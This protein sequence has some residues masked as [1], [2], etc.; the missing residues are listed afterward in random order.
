MSKMPLFDTVMQ[1][2]PA[3]VLDIGSV[4]TKYE[5]T[6]LV[7]TELNHKIDFRLGFAAEAHPR[8][9]IRSVVD[10]AKRNIFDYKDEQHFYDTMVS[11]IEE[12]FFKYVLVSPKDRRVVIVESVL[13]PTLVRDTLARVLFRH[14]E[15]ASVFYISSHLNVL[16]TLAVNTALVVDLGFKE[17]VIVPVYSGVQVL[18]AYQ[19]QP[20]GAEAVH[21]EI[22]R[23]LLEKSVPKDFLT[24]DVIEDIKGNYDCGFY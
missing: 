13:C 21:A 1:E 18:H 5:K 14:F 2:K 3:V 22:K 8:Y 17:A 23:Q 12:I 20:L 6:F 24:D 11:F 15:V 16:T 4:Y 19:A 7:D 9:I 10:D